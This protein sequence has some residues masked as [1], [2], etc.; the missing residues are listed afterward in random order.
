M[1]I[2]F[3]TFI[4]MMINF[5]IVMA[6]LV[7]FLYHPI[8]NMLAKRQNKISDDLNHAQNSRDKWEQMQQEAKLSLEKA[9]AEA[10][11]MVERAR[12]EAEKTRADILNQARRE[13]EEIRA[14][15]QTEIERAKRI[16]KDELREGAVTLA[17]AAAA[18][19]I[20]DKMNKDINEALVHQTLDSIEKGAN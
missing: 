7:R 12:S 6:V 13:A 2:T 10:F 1:E 3:G 4:Y 14:R 5:I 9:Q 15:N 18:K 19:V 11:E 17:I 16:A 20:G 8:Q